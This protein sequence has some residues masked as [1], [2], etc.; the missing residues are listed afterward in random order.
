MI[1]ATWWRNFD[2]YE[3]VLLLLF[4]LSLPLLNPWVRGDG[5]G[6]YAYARAL[7]VDHNLQFE[8]DWQ[9]ANPSFRNS[10]ID[11]DG[12]IDAGQYT[13]TGHLNNHF[14][15]GPALLWMPFL[16]ATH[17]MVLLA[18]RMGAHVRPDG[19]SW[20]YL[21]TMAIVTAACGFVALLI[22]FR[23]ARKYFP[24]CWAFLATLGIWLASSL[25]VYM[26]FN[27]SWSH[28]Q[29][30]FIVAVFV[31]YWDRTRNSRTLQQWLVL[32]LIGGLMMDMY[33]PNAVFLILIPIEFTG[34]VARRLRSRVAPSEGLDRAVSAGLVFAAALTFAFLPTLITRWIIY[35]SPF[36]AGYSEVNTWTLR[37]PLWGKVLFSP[38]HGLFSWTPVLLLATAG[39]LFISRK[40]KL[41]ATA[42]IVSFAAFY[43]MI[44]TYPVWDGISSYGNRFFVSLTPMFILGLAAL[45][46]LFEE[47]FHSVAVTRIS[48]AV[49]ALLAVW[50]VGLMFQWGMHLIPERGP[51]SWSEAFSNQFHIVPAEITGSLEQYFTARHR[52]M[53]K[54]ERKD[55]RQLGETDSS[56]GAS[57]EKK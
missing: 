44:A 38:D 49:L 12:H 28:A 20:P 14:A 45:L 26:Y 40:D 37:F 18:D 2:V 36:A 50:N 47:L 5:V 31:W 52:L 10:R 11:N 30:A 17:G 48:A 23:V 6:Y 3:R 21:D 42:V 22:S 34:Q 43:F 53:Q 57:G 16:T 33:Y 8:K 51:I 41:L 4:L 32:G 7:V 1:L 15:V 27:P 46:T 25:P 29:S 39:F 24:E 56:R 9:N 54:I 13:A 19:Y 55:L 35:G